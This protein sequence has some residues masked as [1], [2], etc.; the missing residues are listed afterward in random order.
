M[1]VGIFIIAHLV[2]YYSADTGSIP[3]R[4]CYMWLEACI[5]HTILPPAET[6]VYDAYDIYSLL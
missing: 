4:S 1:L 6:M 5:S 2:V 3:L